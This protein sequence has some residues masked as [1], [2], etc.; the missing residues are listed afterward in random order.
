MTDLDQSL[1]NFQTGIDAAAYA[2]W[3][4]KQLISH[5]R[6]TLGNTIVPLQGSDGGIIPISEVHELLTKI[7]DILDC[8]TSPWV[9]NTTHILAFNSASRKSCEGWASHFPHLHSSK[10][11][12]S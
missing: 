1:S 3:A 7:H 2:T 5:I 6:T 8:A 11:T 9:G 4:K 12:L 10:D